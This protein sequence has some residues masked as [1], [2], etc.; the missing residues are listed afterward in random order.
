M[1]GLFFTN[2]VTVSWH[3]LMAADRIS[4]E[5]P[6]RSS[7]SRWSGRLK[8]S[9]DVEAAPNA[10]PPAYR[11]GHT[12]VLPRLPCALLKPGVSFCRRRT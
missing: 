5:G 10:L 11:P 3:A 8:G 1:V 9:G 6:S 7:A 4:R 2:T 12:G